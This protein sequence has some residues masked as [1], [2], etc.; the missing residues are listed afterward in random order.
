VKIGERIYERGR[1][2][3]WLEQCSLGLIGVPPEQ[4]P[5]L[6]E[7]ERLREM[8]RTK[9]TLWMA[10]PCPVCGWEGV[11][12]NP[13]HEC[14]AFMLENCTAQHLLE[15]IPAITDPALIEALKESE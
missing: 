5:L 14:A 11:P 7:I 1:E 4:W 6:D 2:Q 10:R 8:I 13:N 15:N 3:G 9:T 12:L